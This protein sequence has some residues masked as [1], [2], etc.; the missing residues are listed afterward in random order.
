M[1]Q[2]SEISS[3]LSEITKS[4]QGCVELIAEHRREING[5]R[6]QINQI[7]NA[8]KHDSNSE[9][10]LRLEKLEKVVRSILETKRPYGLKGIR[11]RLRALEGKS[12]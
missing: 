6:W 5:L 12:N 11:R 8:K 9:I 10:A 4:I 1:S 2:S 7:E 3:A